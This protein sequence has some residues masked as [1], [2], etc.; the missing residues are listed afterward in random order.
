[1]ATDL[2][3]DI[4]YRP[5]SVA[6]W[7]GV[8]A[9]PIAFGL[10]L[11]LRYALVEWACVH[12]TRWMLTAISIPLLVLALTGIPL[13]WRGRRIGEDATLDRVA[14]RVRFMGESAIVLSS[15]FALTIVASAIPDFFIH[16]CS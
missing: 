4:A 12:G 9:G 13:G 3:R 14:K 1:M 6:L 2:A 5:S 8:M 16:P 11:G 10:D 15:V 7:S